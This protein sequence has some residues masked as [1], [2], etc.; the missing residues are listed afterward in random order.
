MGILY[1]F[2]GGLIPKDW[3]SR[4]IA[5][6]Q[7]KIRIQSPRDQVCGPCACCHWGPHIA[8]CFCQTGVVLDLSHLSI[9]SEEDV[10]EA[11]TAALSRE[12]SKLQQ[13]VRATQSAR[14]TPTPSALVPKPP[15]EN[16][17][18]RDPSSAA[19]SGKKDKPKAVVIKRPSQSLEFGVNPSIN[20]G[21]QSGRSTVR[22]LKTGVD[23]KRPSGSN[24]QERFQRQQQQ[25]EQQQRRALSAR[26][27][28]DLPTAPASDATGEGRPAAA[29]AASEAP[30]SELLLAGLR[31]R[32][33]MLTTI[34][35]LPQVLGP[36]ISKSLQ[37]LDLSMNNFRHFD[38]QV[39]LQFPSLHTLELQ[40]NGI[41]RIV[42]WR[43]VADLPPLRSLSLHHNPLLESDPQA[44]FRL[45][46]LL[47]GLTKYNDSV[48]TAK[49][50]Q[51]A[52]IWEVS[53]VR[54]YI[55]RKQRLRSKTTKKKGAPWQRAAPEVAIGDE[56]I[57]ALLSPSNYGW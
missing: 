23:P 12:R 22:V 9:S 49:D 21:P 47:P 25:L 37:W 2:G 24:R 39:L 6:A 8:Y 43:C 31:L 54:A 48:L 15:R 44:K 13:S 50:K 45:Q 30:T 4:R 55:R 42:G 41:R 14:T 5:S 46:S 56:R 40:G 36:S 53:F 34:D 28:E 35:W 51:E 20:G 57:E 27:E 11:L 32:G 10:A 1:R 19:N 33:N 26:R 52:K 7:G 29:R 18:F 38:L 16:G 3:R 17:S